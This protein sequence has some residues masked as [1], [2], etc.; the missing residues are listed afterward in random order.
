MK[1]DD[2]VVVIPIVGKDKVLIQ[3]QYK[4][5]VGR[6]CNGFP[7]GFVKSG[8]TSLATA[9]R[10]LFEE[11]GYTA[12]NWHKIG[13]YYDNVSVMDVKFT[14]F[15]ATLVVDDSKI[16]T[17][18]NPDESESRIINK[19]VYIESLTKIRMIGSCMAIARLYILYNHER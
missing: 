10:E 9:K 14:I 16:G 19:I 2:Y 7:A 15:R 8:E 18:L 4:V 11:T 6:V 13:I 1:Y 17:S 3:E 5:G 12:A